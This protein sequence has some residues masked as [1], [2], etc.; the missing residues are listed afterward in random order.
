MTRINKRAF[1][2]FIAMLLLFAV[3]LTLLL[4]PAA[5]AEE[6]RWTGTL[7]PQTRAGDDLVKQYSSC[8]VTAEGMLTEGLPYYNA[9]Q[10]DLTNCCGPLAA[11]VVLG[12]YDISMPD[13]IPGF[14]SK[15][16]GLY[17]LPTSAWHNALNELYALM[18]VNEAGAGVSES[19]FD[20]GFEDYVADKGFSLSYAPAASGGKIDFGAVKAA[21]DSQKPVLVFAPG[22]TFYEKGS[23][24]DD[25]TIYQSI[26]T[27]ADHIF[28]IEGY[29]KFLCDKDLPSEYEYV[30]YYV[31]D[32]YN[33]GM[34]VCMGDI[35]IHN[36]KG[37]EIN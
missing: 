25:K 8:A 17:L 31:S 4:A 24:Y 16:F 6:P 3:A 2:I 29:K 20:E 23:H 27:V 30:I 35:T 18:Q 28:V 1:P 19:E 33:G 11:I 32:L 36:A 10:T 15:L 9:A 21:I 5:G 34:T 13:L 26:N 14:T 7:L 22:V 12:Y 37:V